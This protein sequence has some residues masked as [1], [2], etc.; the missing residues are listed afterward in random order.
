MKYIN[1]S[2]NNLAGKETNSQKKKEKQSKA[3]HN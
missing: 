3:Q 2:Q 1:K